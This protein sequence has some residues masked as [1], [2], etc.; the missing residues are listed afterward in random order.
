MVLLGKYGKVAANDPD[1][2]TTALAFKFHKGADRVYLA[3][4][5]TDDGRLH[6]RVIDA[7]TAEGVAAVLED[8]HLA[9][10]YITNDQSLQ[11]CRLTRMGP[12][13]ASTAA[14]SPLQRITTE[15]DDELR[16][17]LHTEVPLIRDGRVILVAAAREPGFG[18]KVLVRAASTV[19][20]AP[21]LS[22]LLR[23][24]EGVV[25]ALSGEPC[26]LAEA[27]HHAEP[28]DVVRQIISWNAAKVSEVRFDAATATAT[29]IAANP[30]DLAYLY[31]KGRVNL[32]FT[33]RVCLEGL[34][35][36]VVLDSALVQ[37][38]GE[39]SDGVS[40]TDAQSDLVKEDFRSII[41]GVVEQVAN[42]EIKI[43]GTARRRG[44]GSKFIVL[45]AKEPGRD[46][47]PRFARRSAAIRAALQGEWFNVVQHDGTNIASTVR[48]L[49]TPDGID[50]KK[51][52]VD[53]QAR[54]V[55]VQPASTVMMGKLIGV[56]G[57]NIE[58]ARQAC[59][60]AFG[61]AIVLS[62]P[63]LGD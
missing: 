58:L 16:R 53:E 49:L 6:Q 52:I 37:D 18:S 36:N 43:L 39:A 61:Y 9:D 50:I 32:E 3:L 40:P 60:N 31:G 46:I 33:R 15:A 11:V 5:G 35:I 59:R 24:R 17:V 57:V 2:Y 44:V 12:G 55:V 62:D 28:A 29:V 19:G 1:P 45:A 63:E 47:V 30:R 51:A 41:A 56:N 23:Y 48:R 10:S 8:F 20:D 14:N 54:T 7:A 21:I 34:G 42:G 13:S 4:Y 25:E 22:L 27:G 26:Q 38:D